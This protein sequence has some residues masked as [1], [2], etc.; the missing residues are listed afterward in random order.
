[1]G[2]WANVSVVAIARAG[3]C[4]AL[5]ALGFR[6]ISDDDYARVVI[7]QRFAEAPSWDPSGTSWLPLPFWISGGAMRLFGPA[8]EVA[9][10]TGFVCGVIA[11][12]LVLVSGRAAGQSLR[13]ATAGALI[14]C[15]VPWFVWLGASTTPEALA[16]GLML[17]GVTAS[18]AAKP[19]FRLLGASALGL[20]CWARYEAWPM[21][22][23]F[24]VLCAL[25]AHRQRSLPFALAALIALVPACSWLV[26]GALHHGSAFFFVQRVVAYRRA[27][28]GEAAD[29]LH[30][31]FAYPLRLAAAIELL[32]LALLFATL[33][34]RLR[35]LTPAL[36]RSAQRPL[37]LVCSLLAFLIWGEL[38]DGAA[39]HHPERA[40]LVVWLGLALWCGEL[41]ER[42]ASA[43]HGRPRA[44]V[45]CGA[46]ALLLLSASLLRA[47]SIS[48]Q[49][50]ADRNAE[51]AIGRA[52]AALTPGTGA[53]AHSG[54][55]IDSAGFAYFAVIAGYARP[56]HAAPLDDNDPRHP[57]P[58]ELLA[59]P[60]ALRARVREMRAHWLVV[61][62]ERAELARQIGQ[63]RARND[64]YVL[65]E[66]TPTGS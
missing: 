38:R 56:E 2:S 6:A 36:L 26:H 5:F 57:R 13:A 66:V 54:M 17:L 8:L 12:V 28:G 9:R 65:F 46:V 49:H 43:W 37:L 11:G 32:L 18:R 59:A 4:A 24:A 29:P 48:K 23:V 34:Y 3:S 51:V 1:M 40:L 52:A 55:L 19:G 39:T 27:L 60:E 47:F 25:D 10:W 33:A 31:L 30:V 50:F 35:A 22:A 42:I 61:R 53:G 64:G 7:A 44:L 45:P 14:A 15:S 16:G 41:G 58:R 20:A 21:A 63:E 62:R